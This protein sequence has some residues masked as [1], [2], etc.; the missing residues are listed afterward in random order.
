M[1][2]ESDLWTLRSALAAPSASPMQ[3][4]LDTQP[5]GGFEH[6]R[7]GLCASIPRAGVI[8]NP[9]DHSLP[10][11][12]LASCSQVSWLLIGAGS[13]GEAVESPHLTQR[14]GALPPKS[15]APASPSTL[16]PSSGP[17]CYPRDTK[18][19]GGPRAPW[20]WSQDGEPHALLPGFGLISLP[21]N[22]G[23]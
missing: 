15:L 10:V 21:Q 7:P 1:P 6:Y 8:G 12:M 11:L 23:L 22:P 19:P 17:A 16:T 20:R 2:G 14:I 3:A 9:V 13:R 4:K 18:D 5:R